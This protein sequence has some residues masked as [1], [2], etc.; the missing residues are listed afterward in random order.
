MYTV[1]LPMLSRTRPKRNCSDQKIISPEPKLIIDSRRRE[2]PSPAPRQPATSPR[3][4]Q[5]FISLFNFTNFVLWN[6]QLILPVDEEIRLLRINKIRLEFTCK[7]HSCRMS[8][9]VRSSELGA[10]YPHT[11]LASRFRSPLSTVSFDRSV[12]KYQIKVPLL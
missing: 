7:Q 3:P 11:L 4:A 8:D 2:R 12:N 5:I 10:R 9:V 1:V 6:W